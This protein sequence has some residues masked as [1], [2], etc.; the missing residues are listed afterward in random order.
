M[1]QTK[2]PEHK[3]LVVMSNELVKQPQ[4]LSLVERRALYLILG[5]LKP[6]V[7]RSPSGD[8]LS[9]MDAKELAEFYKKGV[10]GNLITE[11]S[12][13][14][15]TVGEYARV[16]GIRQCDAREELAKVADSLGNRKTVINNSKM[17]GVVNWTSTTLFDKTTDTLV[18]K[19]NEL[20]IPYLCD[21]H[22]YFIKVRLGRVLLLQSTYSWRLYELYKVK[23][24][25]N[26]YVLPYFSLEELY[27]S[28]DVPISRREYKVFKQR[29][30]TPVLAELKEKGVATLVIKERKEG[31]KVV[32]L[33]FKTA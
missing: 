23:R 8:L 17:V 13:Y 22:N 28:M 27:E 11:S 30:L 1:E 6:S 32:G 33:E 7:H 25:E 21:L 5:K 26:R 19:F 3:Y 20:L 12:V 16:V 14:T 15:L 10:R 18:V 4:D 2:Q 24:G 29:I 9:K 31:R